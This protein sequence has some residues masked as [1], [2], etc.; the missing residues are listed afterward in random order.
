LARNDSTVEA[1][2]QQIDPAEIASIGKRMSA[3]SEFN[4][5]I[6][7]DGSKAL[8]VL[9]YTVDSILPDPAIS[10]AARLRVELT[11]PVTAES[12][13]RPA[14]LLA[15]YMLGQAT[16]SRLWT[17]L[18]ENDG[19]AYDVESSIRWNTGPG[20]SVWSLNASFPPKAQDK[21]EA[22]FNDEIKRVRESGFTE[23]ELKDAK[24]GLVKYRQL[25]RARDA[26]TSG[27][28]PAGTKVGW[29]ARN[30]SADKYLDDAIG[31]VSLEDVNAALRKHIDPARWAIGFA[32]PTKSP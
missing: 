6:C 19:L 2:L 13:E 9:N 26:W 21:V 10:S 24:S 29:L 27:K 25:W 5:Y 31:K 17:R 8:D 15:D 14:L 22:A 3:V 11:L 7:P 4:T 20:K 12:T 32:A 16:T 1:A 23:A 18:R 30:P 28:S